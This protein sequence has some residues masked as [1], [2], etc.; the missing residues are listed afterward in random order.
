MAT[1]S[2][3]TAK[4]GDKYHSIY[5]HW[6]G[7]IGHNGTI[8]KQFYNTQEKV[9]EL[10]SLGFLSSLNETIDKCDAYHRDRDEE[11]DIDIVDA[12]GFISEKD[13]N[14]LW[15]GTEWLMTRKIKGEESFK[16]FEL[17]EQGEEW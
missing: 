15:N 2:T 10:L 11:F 5:C 16:P 6:D 13:Y 14:Y 4:I 8:L 7:Y 17:P 3:I 12:V 1:R 9:E